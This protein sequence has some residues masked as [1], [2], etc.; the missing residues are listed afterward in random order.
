MITSK[1]LISAAALPTRAGPLGRY[2][3]LFAQQLREQQFSPKGARA[4]VLQA[5]QLGRWLRTRRVC[6]EDLDFATI[7]TYCAR[8][9]F[10]T[11]HHAAH[12]GRPRGG[13]RRASPIHRHEFRRRLPEQGARSRRRD[14]RRRADDTPIGWQQFEACARSGVSLDYGYAVTGHSAQGLDSSRVIVEKDTHARTTNRRSF[15][16]DITRARD[17]AVV[18]TDSTLRLAQRVR[19]DHARIGALEVVGS[20]EIGARSY[21]EV[22]S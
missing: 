18:V 11:G 7:D 17:T 19:S 6:V 22:G 1:V 20:A 8:R 2:I 5:A 13:G 15:Y 9:R 10:R 21:R 4:Q 3:D 16:T 14:Q 12:R